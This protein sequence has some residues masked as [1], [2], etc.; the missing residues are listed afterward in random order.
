MYGYEDGAREG[1]GDEE[2]NTR[3]RTTRSSNPIIAANK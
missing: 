1:G 2:T 3:L